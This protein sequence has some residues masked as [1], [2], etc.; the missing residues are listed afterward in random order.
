MQKVNL[1]IISYSDGASNAKMWGD[2]WVKKMVQDYI[3]EDDGLS[4]HIDITES[5]SADVL[6]HMFGTHMNI[7]FKGHKIIW[8]HSHPNWV[9]K[10]LLAPYNKIYSLSEKFK[11]PTSPPSP[12][13]NVSN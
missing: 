1:K 11:T 8:I 6:L 12:C 7:R 9:N 10:Q 3:N 2:Y 13:S 4:L 5:D